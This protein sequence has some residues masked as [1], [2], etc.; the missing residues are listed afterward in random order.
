MLGRNVNAHSQTIDKNANLIC[1]VN[2]TRL[3]VHTIL[4]VSNK[5]AIHFYI[6]SALV[7]DQLL[8]YGVLPNY[9]NKAKSGLTGNIKFI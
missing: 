3:D 7:K 4:L 1:G 6:L 8:L 2:V 5:V 9:H